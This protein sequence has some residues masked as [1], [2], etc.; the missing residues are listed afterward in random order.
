MTKRARLPEREFAGMLDE[1]M[2]YPRDRYPVQ[3]LGEDDQDAPAAA[4]EPELVRDWAQTAHARSGVNCSA[5]HQPLDAVG[6]SGPWTDRPGQE[7]CQACHGAEVESFGRGLHGMRQANGLPAMTPAEARLPMR[8]A[9]AHQA[10]SCSSCHG[11]HGFDLQRAAVDACLD[12]HADGHSLAYKESPHFALWQQELAGELPAGS[13]VSCAS[14]HMPRVNHDVSDWVSRILVQ[15][16][17]SASLQPN[18]KMIRPACLHCHGLGF[19]IDALAD[20]RL[21]DN[22]FRGAPE[23]P[24]ASMQMAE[25]VHRKAEEEI[26]AR[27]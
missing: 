20:R 5:C 12:C 13:G 4:A 15:H 8:E 17:Q 25:L 22:N 16:N 21:I 3:P 10:L 27:R 26:R 19:S 1:L 2:D 23:R 11:A 9:A 14:C 18:D 24:V 7:A 6:A